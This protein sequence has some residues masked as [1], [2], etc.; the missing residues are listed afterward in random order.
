MTETTPDAAEE[1]F[2]L[3]TR[4]QALTLISA[5]DA[6]RNGEEDRIEVGFGG[7]N[8]AVVGEDKLRVGGNMHENVEGTRQLT[9]A[10]ADTTIR[11]SATL[12]FKEYGAIMAGVMQEKHLNGSLLLAGMSDDLVGGGGVRLTAAVDLWAGNLIGMEEK[13][14]TAIADGILAEGYAK[15]F[16]REYGA[17]VHLAGMAVFSGNVR[18]TTATGFWA[19]NRVSTGVRQLNP[20][21]GAA[22]A[23]PP[24]P[25]PPPAPPL[26][27]LAMLAFAGRALASAATLRKGG[28]IADAASLENVRHL[29]ELQT[30]AG[31]ENA[32]DVARSLEELSQNID[33]VAQRA[34]D[35]D[36]LRRLTDAD[37]DVSGM[38]RPVADPRTMTPDE[39][40]EW[41]RQ[42]DADDWLTVLGGSAPQ[43]DEPATQAD[44]GFSGVVPATMAEADEMLA[45]VR[46]ALMPDGFDFDEAYS[47]FEAK[48]AADRVDTNIGSYLVLTSANNELLD[49][50]DAMM[51]ALARYASPEEAR[52]LGEIESLSARRA[53]MV[54]AIEEARQ[55]GDIARVVE[56][57]S[58]LMGFDATA[59]RIL[60]QASGAADTIRSMPTPKLPAGVNRDELHAGLQVEIDRLMDIH[61]YL[62]P[63]EQQQV[64]DQIGMYMKAQDMVA[65]GEDPRPF[66]RDQAEYVKYQSQAG[67]TG[68]YPNRATIYPQ[69]S[70]EVIGKFENLVNAQGFQLDE[71]QSLDEFLAAH[72]LSEGTDGRQGTGFDDVLV[73]E[74]AGEG[75]QGEFVAAAGTA[76]SGLQYADIEDLTRTDVDLT[77][78]DPD[79]PSGHRQADAP[80][81]ATPPAAGAQH[82][83]P[84]LTE[85][86]RWAPGRPVEPPDTPLDTA[87]NRTTLVFQL[88]K[89]QAAVLQDLLKNLPATPEARRHAAAIAAE[90]QRIFGLALEAIQ[91]GEDPLA[92]IS[93]ELNLARYADTL[94]DARYAEEFGGARLPGK[95]E[96]ID[97]VG[98]LV[99]QRLL[100]A[101]HSGTFNGGVLDPD[102]EFMRIPSY[103]PPRRRPGPA[104]GPNLPDGLE[105]ASFDLTVPREIRQTPLP[106][107]GTFLGDTDALHKA[108]ED[109]R[110]LDTAASSQYEDAGALLQP[111]GIYVLAGPS[112]PDH[113][114]R[115]LVHV[116]SSN[117]PGGYDL[118]RGTEA[119]EADYDA[120]ARSADDARIYD[121]P[122]DAIFDTFETQVRT[123]TDQSLA[124]AREVVAWAENRS[125]FSRA[126]GRFKEILYDVRDLPMVLVNWLLLNE[127]QFDELMTIA[128]EGRRTRDSYRTSTGMVV[129]LAEAEDLIRRADGAF[130]AV[131]PSGGTPFAQSTAA[132]QTHY[133]KLK[134]APAGES[135]QQ[136]FGRTTRHTESFSDADFDYL[137]G[138]GV[139]RPRTK[140]PDAVVTPPEIPRV[141]SSNRAPVPENFEDF[142]FV[143]SM[144]RRADGQLSDSAANAN[145]LDARISRFVQRALEDITDYG[146]DLLRQL[147]PSIDPATLDGMAANDIRSR[148]LE[149]ADQA[150]LAGDLER[151]ASIR[152]SIND[153]ETTAHRKLFDAVERA[154]EFNVYR[155]TEVPAHIDKQAFV[156]EL[157][158]RMAYYQEKAIAAA[159]DFDAM[160]RYNQAM[161]GL[162]VAKENFLDGADPLLTLRVAIEHEGER[163]LDVQKLGFQDALR[164]VE[165]MWNARLS[166]KKPPTDKQLQKLHRNAEKGASINF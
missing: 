122:P 147:D 79:A 69:L 53:A 49:Q 81:D 62:D 123:W 116:L 22:A 1:A 57:E 7:M 54:A 126:W 142:D 75:R 88:R 156:E 73:L 99:V 26:A 91:R 37:P 97:S 87:V 102:R 129:T 117:S 58:L 105:Y 10:R 110:G 152:A 14:G 8:D 86:W 114:D 52:R 24:P 46:L 103:N 11:G 20:G 2:A 36:T 65:N 113:Y 76:D 148:M 135:W 108:Y 92:L 50:S 67:T 25:A 162:H 63:A 127:G 82:A 71:L 137:A 48:R 151:A 101:G 161:T 56:L 155:R 55:A 109:L 112:I 16:E 64:M 159:G 119:L 78:R 30:A 134:L 89:D 104:T 98:D 5:D 85:S 27:S 136:I 165:A 106:P 128:R 144:S 9:A 139:T 21:G 35:V 45:E 121:M 13:L 61:P 154:E 164:E 32:A 158:R 59:M 47:A 90:K 132:A 3:Q 33:D 118:I 17:A 42:N 107:A 43:A 125:V 111:E 38:L 34:E 141:Y 94:D 166:G 149:L 150:E 15:M 77:L 83:D 19:L 115:S 153:L 146:R 70:L 72:R 120:V 40:A 23:P 138:P 160:E 100:E 130:D 131:T 51:A 157:D 143:W 133:N 4:A 163:L 28:I 18:V 60:E 80:L 29:E 96:A 12:R 145:Q 31:L 6:E 39:L 41:R 124:A 93:H 74:D 140:A 84:D 44:E 95:I 68:Q 66:L